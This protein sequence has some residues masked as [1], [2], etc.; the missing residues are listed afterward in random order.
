MYGCRVRIEF[1]RSPELLSR[2]DPVP[3]KIHHGVRKLG[4][5]FGQSIIQLDR[6]GRFGLLPGKRLSIWE[7]A[8]FTR[9][10]VALGQCSMRRR[11]VG[12][13]C[14]RFMQITVALFG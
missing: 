12:I 14:N 6:P 8:S 10:A 2:S 3:T 7:P 4:M 11:V 5:A 9:P 13:F 1:E